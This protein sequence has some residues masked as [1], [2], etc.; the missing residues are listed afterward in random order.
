MQNG[1][2]TGKKLNW[3]W[4]QNVFVKKRNTELVFPERTQ[5]ESPKIRE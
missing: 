4:K 2:E 1:I 5:L 3:K